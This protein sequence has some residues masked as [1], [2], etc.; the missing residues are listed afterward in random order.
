MSRSTKVV[1]RKQPKRNQAS[2]ILARHPTFFPSAF[3]RPAMTKDKRKFSQNNFRKITLH[4]L[5]LGEFC[6][7][8]FSF[9]ASCLQCNSVISSAPKYQ[10]PAGRMKGERSTPWRPGEEYSLPD[11]I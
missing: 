7:V 5:H 3:Y 8:L 9:F 10:T 1:G 4:F 2:Y 6:L 11:K